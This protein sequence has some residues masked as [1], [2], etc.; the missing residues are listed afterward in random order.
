MKYKRYNFSKV[1]KSYE[2]F[3]AAY[4]CSNPNIFFGFCQSI[5]DKKLITK[6]ANQLEKEKKQ[7]EENNHES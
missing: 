5:E 6:Y 3:V 1:E 7:I 4:F 2:N